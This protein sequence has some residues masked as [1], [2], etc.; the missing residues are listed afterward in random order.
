MTVPEQVPQEKHPHIRGRGIVSDLALGLSDGVV[1]NLA[2]LAGF[3]GALGN[4]EIIRLAGTASMCAGAV[5]MFF[6]GLVA[7]RTEHDLFKADSAREAYEIEHEPEEEKQELRQFYRD[8]GLS[9]DETDL[10]V[11]RITS[12][13]KKWLEDMLMHELTLNEQKLES[14]SK[15]AGVIGLS[16][17][18]GALVPLVPYLVFSSKLVSVIFSVYVSLIFLFVVGGWKGELSRRKFLRAGLE[19]FLVGAL[20]SG[21]LYLIGSL[22]VFA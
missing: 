14:P 1:T 18:I 6:G 11:R 16:F 17:L 9:Q 19:M 12:D 20:A 5:S 22:L 8:K 2:F 7:G 13:R 4:L 21:I 3:S 10:V 15:V